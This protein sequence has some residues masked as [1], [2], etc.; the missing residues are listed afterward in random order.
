MV[1]SD[2]C[3]RAV[4]KNLE[5]YG[6]RKVLLRGG[7]QETCDGGSGIQEDDMVT[8]FSMG[9][10]E[11]K[12]W[13]SMIDEK[14]AKVVP[15]TPVRSPPGEPEMINAWEL[16]EGLEDEVSPFR[17]PNHVKSFSF[18]VIPSPAHDPCDLPKSRFR[19]DGSISPEPVRSGG[20][21]MDFDPEIIASSRK[22]LQESSP[23]HPF[24]RHSTNS[25]E[26][27]STDGET[28][29]STTETV[30]TEEKPEFSSKQKV[31]LY[32]TSLRGVRKT[33][34]DCCHVRLILKGIG[35]R[36][37]ERDVSMHSGF[38]DE[39]SDLLRDGIYRG[40]LP[41]V[42]VGREYIGGAEDVTRMHEEGVLEKALEGC[43]RMDEKGGG[44]GETCEACGDIRFVPCETCSGSC[45]V[46]YYEE[47]EEEEG[48][49]GE[50]LSGFK[51]CL[52]CNE[53]G[54]IRCPNCCY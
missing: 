26:N 50:G 54:L 5:S 42:F 47:G 46:Y 31:V 27:A 53:N 38:K 18:D 16:M 13:S 23:D 35:V 4:S 51:R 19:D 43:Q 1:V 49:E 21:V 14:I 39:L 36:V 10:I 6:K 30:E 29:T 28:Q 9:L 2:C 41:R 33:Y 25:Q 24:H 8:E 15:R 52:D 44:V 7:D 40:G 48:E 45:K 37:D 11:A 12:T 20:V 17:S 3:P 34:E 22:S 32:F